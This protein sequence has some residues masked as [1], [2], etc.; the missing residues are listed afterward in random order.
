MTAAPE[1]APIP[2]TVITGFLGSGKTT[3]L[4]HL[5]GFPELADTAVLINELGEVGLDHHLVRQIDENVVV[6]PSGC[7]CCSIRD[8]LGVAMRELLARRD[9]GTVPPFRRLALETTGLADPVPILHTLLTEPV[10]D[11]AFRL[12]RVVATV[13]AVHGDG[14]L[15]RQPESVKQA[16]IADCIV[17]TKTDLAPADDVAALELRL[18]R[19]NPS[20]AIHAQGLAGLRP[21]DLLAGADFD[22]AGKS[23][24]VQRGFREEGAGHGDADGHALGH[25]GHDGHEHGT[26]HDERI[27]ACSMVFDEPI[28][29]SAF[30]IWLTM[31]LQ[32][33]GPDILRVKGLLDVPG[34]SG[35]VVIDGVQHIVH[36]PIHLERWTDEDRRSRL[37][38]IARDI[39]AGALEASLRTFNRAARRLASRDDGAA[40]EPVATG[41]GRQLAG[42]PYRRAGAPSWMK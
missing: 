11:R 1:A 26:R 10:I 13:D 40:A 20:A 8:D 18:R 33:R 21:D 19:L 2:V 23:A 27:A 35:P 39:P 25:D 36:D 17:V 5:L 9:L 7:L 15:A 30:C 22:P 14:Q 4:R 16:A 28:D 37:V 32:A 31:L 12:R 38:V 29:W 34:R 41:A 42:R 6:L 24:D 3:L